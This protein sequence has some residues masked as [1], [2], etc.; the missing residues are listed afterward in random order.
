MQNYLFTKNDY[1]NEYH[2]T[3]NGATFTPGSGGNPDYFAFDGSDDYMVLDYIHPPLP[4][5]TVSLWVK[6]ADIT[7][8]TNGYFISGTSSSGSNANNNLHLGLLNS[9]R[10]Y[11]EYGSQWGYLTAS[12]AETNLTADTWAMLSFVWSGSSIKYY[13]NGVLQ[14]TTSG[15][16]NIGSITNTTK[17]HLGRFGAYNGFYVDMDL[18]QLKI[19]DKELTASELVTEFNK[20]KADYGL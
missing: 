7:P 4:E 12:E 15:F 2:G 6:F 20:Y 18:G 3:N 16:S 17:L 19:Y 8:S 13:K 11:A 10:L 5:T 9:G 14:T 1:P